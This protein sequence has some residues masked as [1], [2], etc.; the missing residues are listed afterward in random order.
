MET[1][2]LG[3]RPDVCQECA[4]WELGNDWRGAIAQYDSDVA[5]GRITFDASGYASDYPGKARTDASLAEHITA[6]AP[7]WFGADS[8]SNEG[9]A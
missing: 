9:E 4:T 6:N 8:T 5:S 2:A 3:S 1:H 7:P